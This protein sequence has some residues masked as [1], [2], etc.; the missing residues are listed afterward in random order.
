MKDAI[1]ALRKELIIKDEPLKAYNM[2]I[3]FRDEHGIDLKDEIDRTYKMISHYFDPKEFD[4]A[5]N[6]N[7]QNNN[8]E[9]I[10]PICFATD[11]SPRY[12]RYKWV[13]D[14][15]DREK[16]KSYMDM[17]CYVGSMVTTAA[18]KGI[19]STGV[20]YTKKVVEVARRRAREVNVDATFYADDV[21]KFDKVKAEHVSSMEVLEHIID[22]ALYLDHLA[23]LATKWVYVSTPNGPY[24]DGEGNL[25]NWDYRGPTDRRGHLFVFTEHTLRKILED[26]GMEIDE[27][28]EGEDLLLHVKYRRAKC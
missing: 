9:D 21:T 23:N 17:G 15:L 28:I 7:V 5:Y 26:Q 20:E 18:K 3:R 27:L 11:A 16:A 13:Q 10:E 8:F 6:D 22:P 4:V 14:H 1:L 12:W 25:P 2:L 24:G 19:E